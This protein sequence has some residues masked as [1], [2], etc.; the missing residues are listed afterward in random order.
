[1]TMSAAIRA[2]LTMSNRCRFMLSHLVLSSRR[3]QVASPLALWP[4]DTSPN[5]R[6]VVTLVVAMV[7]VIVSAA[8]WLPASAAAPHSLCVMRTWGRVSGPGSQRQELEP[9]PDDEAF[10]R[11][12]ALNRSKPSR[13]VQ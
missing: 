6:K 11:M 8:A 13:T 12:P 10:A 3:L 5:E 7:P 1:M 4:L 2:L 9:E